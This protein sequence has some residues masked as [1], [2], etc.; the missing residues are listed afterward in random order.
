MSDASEHDR[1]EDEARAGSA[2]SDDDEPVETPFDHPLFL[3]VVLLGL[4]L[5]FFWDGFVVP[6][7]GHETFNRG[8]FA[9][10]FVAT[11][12]YGYKGIKEMRERARED[13]RPND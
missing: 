3:P 4:S 10:L 2:D 7:E 5:W 11:C 12:W 6:L 1:R 9:V 13:S 8:G